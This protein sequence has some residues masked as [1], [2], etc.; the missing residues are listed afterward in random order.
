MSDDTTLVVTDLDG[1]LWD[2][3]IIVA[4]ETQAALTELARRGITVLAATGG[5][6]FSVR[7]AFAKN[8]LELPAVLLNGSLGFD[9]RTGQTFHQ[10]A[11]PDAV[12]DQ[13]ADVFRAADLEPAVYTADHR[14]H[15]GATPTTQ[16]AHL[17]E[18]A[19]ELVL[20]DNRIAAALVFATLGIEKDRLQP[21]A[22]ALTTIAGVV[23]TFYPDYLYD[24]WS[25]MVQPPGV[26]KWNGVQ[27][28]RA[29][30]A[31]TE[32][33]VIAIG[34]GGNDPEML[35]AAD[36]GVAVSSGDQSAIDAANFL[37]GA[38]EDGGWAEVLD[39]L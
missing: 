4:P 13:V 8:G 14:V 10:H 19:P 36:V 32:C 25:I 3:Q 24:N 28:Y 5:S 31:L 21:A 12:A 15:A 30:H 26:S 11:F 7:T 37:I 29:V 18:I 38:P 39:L 16:W 6:T 20:S 1:S 34:D 9:Y 35:E 23:P 22:D 17:A 27:A 2:R 33:R